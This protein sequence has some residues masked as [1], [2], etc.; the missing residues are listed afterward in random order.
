MKA[1]DLT[2]HIEKVVSGFS[3]YNKYTLGSELRDRTRKVL[4]MIIRGN[5]TND[6]LQILLD[7]RV[8]LEVFKVFTRL[9][10]ESHTFKSR[11]SYFFIAEWITDIIGQNEGWIKKREV[12]RIKNELEK[13]NKI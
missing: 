13:F 1:Y 11:K 4:E 5:N 8:E 2:L 3:R 9:C 10:H 7:L 12:G 6:R